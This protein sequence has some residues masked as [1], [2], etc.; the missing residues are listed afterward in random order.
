[1]RRLLALSLLSLALFGCNKAEETRPA[2]MDERRAEPVGASA[3]APSM[4]A[5]AM[6][7]ASDRAANLEGRSAPD[8]AA[9]RDRQFVR[10]ADL[11]FRTRSVAQATREIEELTAR[12]GGFVAL[13]D[14]RSTI[15][16]TR[17]RPYGKDSVVGFASVDVANTMTLRVPNDRL[18]SLLAH[19]ARHATFLEHRTIRAEDVGKELRRASRESRRLEAA[20]KRLQA[21]AQDKAGKVKDLAQVDDQALARDDRAADAAARVEDLQAEVQLSTV[22]L[23]FWQHAA[24]TLDTL[25]RPLGETWHEPFWGRVGRA[26]SDGWDGAMDLALWLASHWVLIIF[27]VGSLLGW[28]ILRRQT[29]S[30]P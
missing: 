13:N 14:M 8:M 7:G 5:E 24:T 22:Q 17:E 11:R 15:R 18:D 20:G 12:A 9:A 3:P 2:S 4:P 28:R 6:G 16:D 30:V 21:M 29:P 27:V 23:S 26:F 19:I 10:S 25:P 1:M